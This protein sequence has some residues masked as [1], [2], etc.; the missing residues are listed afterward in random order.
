MLWIRIRLVLPSVRM[1]TRFASRDWN[2]HPV[3]RPIG[4]NPM[5]RFIRYETGGALVTHYDAGYDYNDGHRHTLMSV[6][7]TLN[8]QSQALGGNTRLLIDS[9]RYFSLEERNHADSSSMALSRE[10]LA[11]VNARPGDV[12]VFDHRLRHDAPIWYGTNS[13]IILRTDITFERCAPHAISAPK[14]TARAATTSESWI[15][16]PTYRKAFDSLGSMAAL[17]KA[18]YLDEGLQQGLLVDPRWW[19]ATYDKLRTISYVR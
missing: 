7:L 6:V 10:S 19:T 15:C 4:V 2:G 1:F 17:R 11:N 8:S 18:G 3:W 12:L 13:R 16:D 5:L 9:Q 14:Y